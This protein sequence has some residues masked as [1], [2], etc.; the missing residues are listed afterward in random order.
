MPYRG[1]GL[2]FASARD[3]IKS[4]GELYPWNKQPYLDM[5]LTQP[6]YSNFI[7][8]K[9]LN[10]L[11]S[12]FHDAT[13]TFSWDGETVFFTRNYLKNKKKLSANQEGLSNMQILKAESIRINW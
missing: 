1:G 4:N 8:E 10:N 7:P 12:S 6:E 3:T 5:Y 11:E 9:F 2:I 13:I